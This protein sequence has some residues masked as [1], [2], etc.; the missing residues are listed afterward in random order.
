[1]IEAHGS[2][3]TKTALLDAVWPGTAIEESNLSVQMAQL[4]K[5]IGASPTA[6]P[7]PQQ[8]TTSAFSSTTGSRF[9][10]VPGVPLQ[11]WQYQQ[12]K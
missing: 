3:V 2:V 6:A 8:S 11:R 12:E 4:R 10:A 5:R 9:R 1:M 7:S